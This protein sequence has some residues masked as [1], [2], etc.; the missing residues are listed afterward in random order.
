MAKEALWT[1]QLSEAEANRMCKDG[2]ER[3]AAGGGSER[4][5]KACRKVCWHHE[6]AAVAA[7]KDGGP[8]SQARLKVVGGAQQGVAAEAAKRIS[9]GYW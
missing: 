2:R 9:Y 6:E 5:E 7:S 8:E 4:P 1:Q 3:V